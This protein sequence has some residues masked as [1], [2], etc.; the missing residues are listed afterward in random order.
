MKNGISEKEL[1][2]FTRVA[3]RTYLVQNSNFE[4][5]AREM[6]IARNGSTGEKLI[7]TGVGYGG[8]GI[9]QVLHG[10][11]YFE[12]KEQ[13]IEALGIAQANKSRW[14][15]ITYQIESSPVSETIWTAERE[16]T[17]YDEVPTEAETEGWD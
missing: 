12:T 16:P 2:F 15:A 17:I 11:C 5:V 9:L 4:I 7:A 8:N 14:P 3:P 10:P 6:P 13:Q 1:P